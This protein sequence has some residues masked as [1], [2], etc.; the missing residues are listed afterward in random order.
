MVELF[1]GPQG[2]FHVVI[3]LEAIF[4]ELGDSRLSGHITG[5]IDGVILADTAPLLDFRC[6]PETDTLQSVGTLL[7]WDAQPED[8]DGKT[9]QI[10]ASVTDALGRVVTATAEATI[11]DPNL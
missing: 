3:A 6:N 10:E 11:F 9:A 4:L 1:H 7:I 5:T 8:L 2:G